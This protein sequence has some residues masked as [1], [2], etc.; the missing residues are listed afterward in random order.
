M[1]EALV[2]KREV[3]VLDLINQYGD[4]KKDKSIFFSRDR[5]NTFNNKMYAWVESKGQEFKTQI[6]DMIMF[7]AVAKGDDGY[8]LELPE[9]IK[10]KRQLGIEAFRWIVENVD[11]FEGL[12]AS[13]VAH[14]NHPDVYYITISE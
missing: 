3:L 8:V 12:N 9:Y 2:A 5:V 4:L 11:I 6:L 10:A 7:N 1:S 14:A 13:I